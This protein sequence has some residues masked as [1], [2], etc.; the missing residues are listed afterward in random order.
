MAMQ[1]AACTF[2]FQNTH[3][4]NL[5]ALARL[6]ELTAC[7]NLTIGDL[8]TAVAVIDDLVDERRRSA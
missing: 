1:L 6:C 5:S 7:F 8:S 4:H 3:A 2:D